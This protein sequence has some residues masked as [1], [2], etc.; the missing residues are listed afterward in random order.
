LPDIDIDISLGS[1]GSVTAAQSRRVW[2]IML[3]KGT[4]FAANAVGGS[5]WLLMAL[6]VG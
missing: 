4:F 5:E 2:P 1:Q 3:L 6:H